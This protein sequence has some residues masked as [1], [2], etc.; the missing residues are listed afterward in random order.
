M[1]L[2]FSKICLDVIIALELHYLLSDFI[3]ISI[4]ISMAII[5]FPSSSSTLIAGS[6][7]MQRNGVVLRFYYQG[8]LH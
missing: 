4:S 5:R 1:F 3:D 6:H 2:E 7:L 8:V